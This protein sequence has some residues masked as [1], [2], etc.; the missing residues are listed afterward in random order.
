[1]FNEY[2]RQF[3]YHWRLQYNGDPL[4]FIFYTDKFTKSEPRAMSSARLVRISE[5][6]YYIYLLV[7]NNSPILSITSHST[8][9]HPTPS[10]LP[11]LL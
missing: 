10:T 4:C 11:L 3:K 8:H 6:E 5:A 9:F 2:Y 7:P 1:M